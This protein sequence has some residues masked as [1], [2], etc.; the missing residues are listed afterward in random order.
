[1]S[2]SGLIMISAKE[3]RKL[4]GFLRWPGASK[5][6]FTP[7]TSDQSIMPIQVTI[8]EVNPKATTQLPVI[9]A[10]T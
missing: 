7:D 10:T 6:D 5:E 8:E 9:R 1:M 3:G 2:I 4:I